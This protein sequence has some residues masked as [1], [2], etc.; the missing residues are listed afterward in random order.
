M[1]LHSLQD[2]RKEEIVFL[3]KHRQRSLTRSL[4][5]RIQVFQ[6]E[7]S[8]REIIEESRRSL[9]GD[10]CLELVISAFDEPVLGNLTGLRWNDWKSGMIDVSD[11]P[12]GE[13]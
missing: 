13:H 11:R 2:K 5:Q 8:R 7:D 10:M 3:S 4:S 1:I 9:P 6:D 12:V